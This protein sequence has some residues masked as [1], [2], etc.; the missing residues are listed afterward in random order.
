MKRNIN[1]RISLVSLFCFFAI[2]NTYSQQPVIKAS[3]DSTQILIGQQTKLHLEIAANKDANLI[4]PM[5]NDTLVTGVEVLEISQ[6][7]TIDIG[8]NRMQ[9]KYDYLIT[10]FDSALYLIP[11]FKLIALEDTVLSNDL[12]LKVSTFPVDVESK[13]IYDIK[14]IVTPKFVLKDY[15]YILWYL[16]LAILIAAPIIAFIVYRLVNKKE[17]SL[18][19]FKKEEIYIPPHIKAIQNLDDVKSRKLWQQGKE[20][21]YYSE[22][23]E[24][25]RIYIE[26]RFDVQAMEMTSSQILRSL[27]GISDID[28]SYNKLNQILVLADLVKFAK[29]RP[30]PEDNELSM[31][32]AYLFV[33]ETKKEETEELKTNNEELI[34]D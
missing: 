26:E 17:G 14:D 31:M 4:L 7:D 33:N 24:I 25:M 34:N 30:L 16:L 19:F 27:K 21:E 5:Y 23:S 32:N 2:L 8:N 20:K 6:P 29:Y 22:I 13:N 1:I 28:N 15:L 18:S 11:P 10:S 12:A 3:I 9:I